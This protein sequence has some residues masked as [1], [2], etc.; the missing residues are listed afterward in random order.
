M[1]EYG[2][3][4]IQTP[5]RRMTEANDL[6]GRQAQAGNQDGETLEPQQL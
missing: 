3:P 4:A 5:M 2:S 6:N 1:T